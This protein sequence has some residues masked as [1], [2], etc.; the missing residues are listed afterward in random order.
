M[1][2][3]K[4]TQIVIL[5]SVGIHLI[6]EI[7]ALIFPKSIEVFSPV[8]Q[9]FFISYPFSVV[10]TAYLLGHFVIKHKK[11]YKIYISLGMIALLAGLSQLLALFLDINIL[12]WYIVGFSMGGILWSQGGDFYFIRLKKNN[13]KRRR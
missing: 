4:I 5:S 10:I 1:K 11:T 13:G 12:I 6:Y 9:D 3:K 8:I 2:A 7:L